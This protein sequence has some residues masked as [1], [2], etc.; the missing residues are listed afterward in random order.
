MVI[1]RRLL[2]KSMLASLLVTVLLMVMA[3]LPFWSILSVI[4]E[5]ALLTYALII[6]SMIIFCVLT[7]FFYFDVRKIIERIFYK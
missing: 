7:A 2:L 4:E 6:S 3:F 5:S 1:N